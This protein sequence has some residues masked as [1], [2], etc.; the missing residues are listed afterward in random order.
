MSKAFFMSSFFDF[1]YCKHNY[2]FT[3]LFY[4]TLFLHLEERIANMKKTYLPFAVLFAALLTSCTN[5]SP[6]DLIETVPS[7]SVD[8][9]TYIKPVMDNNCV[10]C[11]AAVPNSGAPMSLV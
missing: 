6:N 4:S 3:R 11:H 2:L 10:S 1:L 9:V 7:G 5:D 8:Y